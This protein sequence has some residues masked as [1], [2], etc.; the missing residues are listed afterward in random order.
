M[1]GQQAGIP[2]FDPR[3]PRP[4]YVGWLEAFGRTAAGRRFGITVLARVDPWLLRISGGR[5][6]LFFGAQP[7][8]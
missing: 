2:K 4:F 5:V 8:H 3:E 6:G 1:S 7:R